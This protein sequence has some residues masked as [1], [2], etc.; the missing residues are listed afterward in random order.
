[1]NIHERSFEDICSTPLTRRRKEHFH[2]PDCVPADE[3]EDD[4]CS[5]FDC[6]E[7]IPQ[8]RFP[9]PNSSLPEK[10]LE[11][12][13]EC[14]EEINEFLLD[15]GSPQNTSEGR[16]LQKQFLKLKDQ[17]VKVRVDCDG[18]KRVIK[19]A[20]VDSGRDFIIIDDLDCKIL[21]PFIR[22]HQINHDCKDHPAG[23]MKSLIAID[24]C[25][26]RELILNFG[27]KVSKSPSMINLFFG[28]TL[29]LYLVSLHG[30]PAEIATVSE[31]NRSEVKG[32][33]VKVEND[34]V[35]IS[36]SRGIKDV[37]IEDICLLITSR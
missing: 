29:K 32:E 21:I 30:Q 1:M 22:I 12:L 28:L 14:I 6:P 4:F 34:R 19:G 13:K 3:A 31:G 24:T 15:I 33:L 11:E 8:P 7:R 36:T 35:Q 20:L 2:C 16:V 23:H 5:P 27:E 37:A 10:E 17:F 9:S 26:R 18:D 25:L